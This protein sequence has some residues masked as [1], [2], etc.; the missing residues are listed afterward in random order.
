MQTVEPSRVVAP[1]DLDVVIERL[2]RF[3]D[4]MTLLVDRAF[5]SDWAENEEILALVSV[6][7]GDGV[8]T[9]ALAEHS[10]LSRR[11]VSRLV[12]R[13]SKDG[14][15]RCAAS[16][17]DGRIVVITLAAAGKRS[18][19]LLRSDLRDL[20]ATWADPAQEIADA[21]AV[22]PEV[23]RQHGDDDPLRLL[24]RI[25]QVGV[26]LVDSMSDTAARVHL[27]GRQRAAL[28][29]VAAHAGVRPSQLS[30]SLRVSPA[31]VAY[32]VDQLVAKGL[33]KR[34]LD[35]VTD[36]KRAVILEVTPAGRRVADL[37]ADGVREQAGLL[38]A[39]FSEI[40][41]TG[42]LDLASRRR[43]G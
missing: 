11:A 5:G 30:P 29:Q 38:A 36:D 1:V 9:R 26:R 41:E 19:G 39:I 6:A 15:A 42:R 32:V 24:Q 4:E 27:G 37:I 17:T 40:A 14:L 3:S 31:G 43:A 18:T 34:R 35:G 16:P 25:V 33:V 12:A 22:P 13:L 23:V 8:S 28:S 7:T 10:G 20:F 2:G 21:L